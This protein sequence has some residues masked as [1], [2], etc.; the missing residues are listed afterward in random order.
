[1]KHETIQTSWPEQFYARVIRL[2]PPRFYAAHAPAMQQAFRDALSDASLPRRSLIPLILRD[3]VISLMK[4]HISMMR[5]SSPR[6]LLAV[7][8]FVLAGIATGI[9]LAL[10][11]IPQNVLRSGLNDPQ[12]QLA[13][14]L[15]TRL[16]QGTTAADAVPTLPPIDMARSLAPFVIV[17]DDQGHPLASQAELN[18]SVPAPP[19]GVFDYVRQ[20]GEDRLSWQPILGRNGVRIAAVVHRVGGAHPGFVLAGRNMR[21]VEERIGN[22]QTMA[23]FTW[24]GML[25]LIALGSILFA[26]YT[27]PK[28][29]PP[30]GSIPHS[31]P[32]A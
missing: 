10:Y 1:M 12:I 14:D 30:T 24:L 8:A 17:Y 6:A 25:T 23:G 18:G 19:S 28:S 26:I 22:V 3:L 29:G 16:E 2:Y 7:S 27:R 20:H 9:A 4:E 13:N 5:A 32:V 15:A 11:A 21:E 31:A